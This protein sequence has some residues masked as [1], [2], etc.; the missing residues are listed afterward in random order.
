MSLNLS[1]WMESGERD[2][3]LNRVS[4]QAQTPMVNVNTF[5]LIISWGWEKGSPGV[6]VVST[7]P[8]TSLAQVVG[9]FNL[10][11]EEKELDKRLYTLN[12]QQQIARAGFGI[13]VE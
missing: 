3:E 7:L 12:Q 6:W 4:L 2:I 8:R 5:S 1:I 11:V 9:Q 10:L 13:W